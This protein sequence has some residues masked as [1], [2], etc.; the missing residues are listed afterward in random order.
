MGAPAIA[1]LRANWRSRL[2]MGRTLFDKLWDLHAIASLGEGTDL[3]LI[4]RILLHERTGSV[5]LESLA[6]AGRAVAVPGPGVRDDGSSIVDTL[7]G[8]GDR[9]IMPTGTQF[10]TATRRGSAGCRADPV[11]HRRPAGRASCM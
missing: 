8:R 5:A 10:I 2:T 3:L 7:P 9:T 11:R 4:D 6:E 1:E